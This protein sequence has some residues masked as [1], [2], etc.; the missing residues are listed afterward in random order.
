MTVGITQVIL[1]LI[2]AVLLF[3]NF[4]GVLKDFVEGIVVFKVTVSS[5]SNSKDSVESKDA[6]ASVSLKSP[7]E[8]E[9]PVESTSTEATM[10]PA[11]IEIIKV[12]RWTYRVFGTV[13]ANTSKSL[14]FFVYEFG[15]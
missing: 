4:R 15:Q 7:S 3:G 12:K 1:I 14:V 10:T 8:S 13:R 9:K 5:S 2:V 6:N 11:L